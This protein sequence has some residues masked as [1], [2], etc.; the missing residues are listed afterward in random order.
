MNVGFIWGF[1]IF[2]IP[3]WF[4]IYLYLDAVMP[5]DYGVPK[6]PCF[7]CMKNNDDK[8]LPIDDLEAE[9]VTRSAD[10][11]IFNE[12]DPIVIK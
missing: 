2:S 6:H 7:C 8:I 4:F 1:L 11:V 5:S 12:N 3:M 10:D 9:L